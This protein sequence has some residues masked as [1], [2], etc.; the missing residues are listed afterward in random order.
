MAVPTLTP[1]STTTAVR[2][3]VTG[4]P[5][6]VASEM[7]FGIYSDSTGPLYSV[8]FLSGACDQVAYTYKKLGGDVLDIELSSSNVYASYEE[9]TLEYSYIVNVHQAKNSLSDYLGNRTGSFDH[10]GNLQSGELS[11]SLKGTHAALKM[12]RFEFEYAKNVMRGVGTEAHVGGSETIHSA[13]FA[14]ATGTQDY[15]L[16]SIIY[17]ASVASGNSNFSYYN[18]VGKNRIEVRKVYYKTPHAMWRFFGYYGGLSV[19][20]NMHYYGQYADESTFEVVPVWQNKLQ[21]IQFEDAINVRLSHFSYEIQNNRL[22]IFPPGNTTMGPKRM[23]V[24]FT[25]KQD[26]WEDNDSKKSGTSGVNN[27]NTL[28][29]G[30]IPYGKINS[31]GKQWIRRFALSLSK[32]TLGQIR[33]KFGTIPIPG[34]NLTLNG[35]ALI[36]EGKEEQDKLREE[37]KTTLD[38]LTYAKLTE[39][40]SSISENTIKLLQ[41]I[42]SPIF[43]G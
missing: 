9:A 18:K 8:N 31:I 19:L 41:N 25:V 39:R 12:P 28:P 33:S 24:E 37:L 13:S 40:D 23:W 3:P 26:A 42:P 10:D 16:Q 4:S 27:M 1:S 30:N 15:D 38:E 22:K 2:L 20:G 5:A 6:N 11:S 14:V 29:F 32:E 36:T 35:V 17:S 43:L 21:A 34:E 7:P